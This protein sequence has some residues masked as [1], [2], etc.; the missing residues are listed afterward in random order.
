MAWPLDAG[1]VDFMQH[2]ELLNSSAQLQD[3]VRGETDARLTALA[4]SCCP[5]SMRRCLLLQSKAEVSRWGVHKHTGDT[6]MLCMHVF[7]LFFLPAQVLAGRGLLGR[8]QWLSSRDLPLG[9]LYWNL[10]GAYCIQSWT[11]WRWVGAECW[12]SKPSDNRF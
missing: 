1:W 12:Y 6:S 4:S 10:M 5:R 3:A 8:G 2:G 11:F 9:L 7:C